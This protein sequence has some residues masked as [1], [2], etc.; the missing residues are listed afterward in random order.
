MNKSGKES[1][2][3]SQS[4]DRDLV[5]TLCQVMEICGGYNVLFGYEEEIEYTWWKFKWKK[6]IRRKG[7]P[8]NALSQIIEYL[9]YK[10][11]EEEKSMK[12]S[13]RGHK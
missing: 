3:Q 6:R 9:N 11:K 13:R 8:I 7:M 1:S 2:Q 12:Q 5:Y 10:S 4:N